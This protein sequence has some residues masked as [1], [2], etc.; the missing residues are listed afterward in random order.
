[1]YLM[2]QNCALKNGQNDK[3]YVMY[4]LPQTQ[5]VNLEKKDTDPHI[6]RLPK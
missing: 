6:S 2:P 3:F 4:I 1:M 5:K